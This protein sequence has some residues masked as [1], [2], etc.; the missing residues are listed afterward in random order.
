MTYICLVSVLKSL[1]EKKGL[2]QN[3]LAAKTGLS[4]RTVQRLEST[5]KAPKGYTLTVLA[6]E[7]DMEPSSLQVKYLQVKRTENS[8]QDTLKIL[9]FSILSFLV[10]PFGNLIFPFIIWRNNKKSELIDEVGRR[11]VNFQILFTLLLNLLLIITPFTLSKLFPNTPVILL[12]ALI[13]FLFNIVVVIK[14]AIKIKDQNFDFLDL[15][16]RII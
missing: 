15:P 4:L 12:V 9:N 7:F 10:I 5:N 6:Q 2:T 3:D 14:T 8:E 1:R 16:I 11:I 13:A